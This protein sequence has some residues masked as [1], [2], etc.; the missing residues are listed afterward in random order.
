MIIR[1][2]IFEI[3]ITFLPPLSEPSHLPLPVL[4]QICGHFTHQWL[5]HAYMYLYVHI[6]K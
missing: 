2:F 5:L 1:F 6:H 3:V 4:L